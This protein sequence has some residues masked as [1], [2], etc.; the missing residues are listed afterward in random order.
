MPQIPR[1]VRVGTQGVHMQP[2]VFTAQL[3]PWLCHILAVEASACYS[4]PLCAY[5]LT[6]EVGMTVI[7]ILCKTLKMLLSM[8]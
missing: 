6:S 7:M 3:Q 2:L 1:G 8:Q 5:F 4:N